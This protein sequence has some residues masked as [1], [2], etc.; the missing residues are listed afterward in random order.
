MSVKE[1]IIERYHKA[2]KRLA[3]LGEP[4][5]EVYKKLESIKFDTEEDC[6]NAN[7]VYAEASEILGEYE[8]AVIAFQECDHAGQYALEFNIL[9]LNAQRELML[10]I[11]RCA[12]NTEAWDREAI[13]NMARKF[14]ENSGTM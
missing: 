6:D 9:Q 7:S 5:S 12:I 4:F 13:A 11:M 3:E 14:L 1:S 10:K 8:R 2:S